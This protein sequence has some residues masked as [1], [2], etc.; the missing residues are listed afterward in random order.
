[1]KKTHQGLESQA[2][3]LLHVP[4]AVSAIF[5]VVQH[6]MVTIWW[7]DLSRQDGHRP[8]EPVYNHNKI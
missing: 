4:A 6:V 3:L 2:L 1:M 7:W 8:I 5:M